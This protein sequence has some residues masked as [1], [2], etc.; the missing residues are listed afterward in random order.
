MRPRELRDGIRWSTAPE[1]TSVATRCM[2]NLKPAPQA[3]APGQ[4]DR[5]FFIDRFGGSGFNVLSVQYPG[6][7]NLPRTV[8]PIISDL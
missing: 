5:P 2:V 8:S 7:G 4:V 6:A 1:S 3:E